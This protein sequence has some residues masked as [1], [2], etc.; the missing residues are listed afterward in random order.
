MGMLKSRH[1]R[2][3]NILFLAVLV[4]ASLYSPEVF[5]LCTGDGDT[6]RIGP[7]HATHSACVPHC[8]DDGGNKDPQD[9]QYAH[10]HASCRDLPLSGNLGNIKEKERLVAAR[11]AD[12]HLS[13]NPAP[14]FVEAPVSHV[15]HNPSLEHI[16]SVILII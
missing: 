15:H 7:L 4:C 16:Q 6:A 2:C 8:A 12:A 5:V 9:A 10:H 1:C 3:I 13:R 14:T 11:A